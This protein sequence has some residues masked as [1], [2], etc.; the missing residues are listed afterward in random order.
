MPFI[1]RKR[2]DETESKSEGQDRNRGKIARK[3]TKQ[4]AREY[5]VFQVPKHSSCGRGENGDLKDHN[6]LT[7]KNKENEKQNEKR[8]SESA[9][10]IE[11]RNRTGRRKW[12]GEDT[13][14][15]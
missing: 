6:P 15:M 8:K 12:G 3:Q 1:K 2:P 13:G 14:A 10:H 7:R 9:T 11:N 4:Y 5:P